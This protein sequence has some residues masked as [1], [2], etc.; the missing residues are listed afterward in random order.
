MGKMKE[1][2]MEIREREE[3]EAKEQEHLEKSSVF[4]SGILCPNCFKTNLL[5]YRQEDLYCEMCGQDF[6]KVENSVRFK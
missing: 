1:L 4:D 6:I 3:Q 2:F 5:E